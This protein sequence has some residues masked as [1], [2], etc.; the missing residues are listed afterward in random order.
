MV[1][2]TKAR[3]PTLVYFEVLR[4]AQ[5]GADVSAMAHLDPHHQQRRRKKKNGAKGGR[6]RR[7]RPLQGNDETL[8][9]GGGAGGSVVGGLRICLSTGR[10]CR[11]LSAS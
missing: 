7:W 5:A 1:F 2:S 8:T 9:Q 10:L 6:G 11:G 4:Y 3:A